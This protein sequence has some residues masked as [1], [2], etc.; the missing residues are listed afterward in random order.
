VNDYIRPSQPIQ[1]LFQKANS[2]MNSNGL[3]PEN[4]R[5]AMFNLPNQLTAL[6]L[7][8]SLVL[9]FF[10]AT[11]WY[12]TSLV[13]FIIAAGT[14]W[15]DGYYARKYDQVT[16]LGRILDP[17]ADKVIICGTFIL[18]AAI[19]RMIAM[20]LWGLQAWMVVIIV[21]RELLV[22][23]LRSFIEQQGGDFSAKMSGKLKMVLQCVAA[24]V[25][26]FF[27][28]Y[29]T[30]DAPTWCLWLMA[31]SVW[32]AILLTVYSGGVYVAAAARLLRKE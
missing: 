18:L 17:F 32:A 27:L 22:T 2:G 23:T 24:G 31:A 7:L 15:L 4:V 16:T 8:L 20:G 26:L 29:E 25:C 1:T 12:I 10:I 11:G 21:G 13:L 28:S 19:P 9:F 3:R 6:R 14:D 5:K 30:A